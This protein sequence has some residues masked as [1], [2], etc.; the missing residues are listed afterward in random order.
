MR[1]RM[2][3]SIGLVVFGHPCRAGGVFRYVSVSAGERGAVAR[4]LE[5]LHEACE[6]RRRCV[7]GM[8]AQ[9]HR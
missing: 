8:R 2:K 5:A 3:P 7:A 6:L 1:R 9:G 4:M